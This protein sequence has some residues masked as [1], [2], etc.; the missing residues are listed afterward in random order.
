MLQFELIGRASLCV[1]ITRRVDDGNW[2]EAQYG[3]H[4]RNR[5]GRRAHEV[6]LP[7]AYCRFQHPCP[8]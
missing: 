2:P 6:H 5:L 8:P 4:H 7:G 1:W 3:R